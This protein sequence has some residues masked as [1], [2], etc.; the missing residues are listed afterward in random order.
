MQQETVHSTVTLSS[1]IHA[2]KHDTY[3]RLPDERYRRKTVCHGCGEYAR[4]EDSGGL[5]GV[6]GKAMEGV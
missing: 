2:D 3:A 4:A 1:L 5:C 6:G